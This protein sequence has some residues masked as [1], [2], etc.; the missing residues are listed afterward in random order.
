MIKSLRLRIQLWHAVILSLVLAA[1]GF[2]FYQQL[3]RTTFDQIDADLI[4]DARI[5]EGTLQTMSA[6]EMRTS[7][8]ELSLELP[9][10][11]RRR[12]GPPY[13]GPPRD[14]D[15]IA[16]EER[17]RPDQHPPP[18]PYFVIFDS[19]GEI[20]D[21]NGAVDVEFNR[22]SNR[23][24]FRGADGRREVWLRGPHDTL[25]VVG[26]D[27]GRATA[28]LLASLTRMFA[29]GI[30]VL[31][32]GLAGGWWLSGK[33]IE[34]IH[35]ISQTAA[36]ISS[37]N[38]S[39]RVDTTAMDDELQSLATTLNAML[40]RLEDSFGQQSRFTADASHELRTPIAV[41][42]SQCELA[43]RRPRSSDDYLKTI[44]ACQKAGDRMKGLVESLLTLARADA[45]LIHLN[46]TNVD[47]NALAVE[48]QSLLQP[49]A[50]EREISISVA[51]SAAVVS[52]DA[53]RIGQVITNL[54]HNAIA[55]NVDGGSVM[56]DTKI[57]GNDAILTVRDTGVGIPADSIEHL[58]DRFYRVDES[59]SRAVGGNGLGLAICK[60]IVDSH[61]G[62]LTATSTPG[63]GSVFEVRLPNATPIS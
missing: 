62:T 24:A 19:A 56:I 58:F 14:G 5:L 57:D 60:S 15:R 29:T 38:L 3:T 33:A 44:A 20:L 6:S 26:R 1:F 11:F 13:D 61:E 43:V 30:G 31:A 7:L 27:I 10:S 55:Y 42:L 9:R 41:I 63:E 39:D 46:R 48:T 59:R 8:S 17:R 36:G 22:P 28:R 23:I 52:I 53:D 12:P 25:I 47:L 4:A 40:S 34:P 51:D 54:V 32:L 50:S 45:G 18:R 37:R 21:A 49:L 2:V 35:R 16:R